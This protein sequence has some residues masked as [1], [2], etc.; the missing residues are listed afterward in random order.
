MAQPTTL[1]ERIDAEFTV[2]EQKIKQL[3]QQKVEQY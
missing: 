1:A 2:A 3:Q